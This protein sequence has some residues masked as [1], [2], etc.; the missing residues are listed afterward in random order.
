[1]ELF[2]L[3][4]QIALGGLVLSALT[5]AF[6]YLTKQTWRFKAVGYTGFLL[7]L[8]AGLLALS[9]APITRPKVEGAK[10]FEVVFD[11]GRGRIVIAVSPQIQPEE[12]ALTLK[13]ARIRRFSSAKGTFEV[14]ARTL[15]SVA[16]G[17]SQLIVL[18][19]LR[20]S[21]TAEDEI[22]IDPEGFIQLKAALAQNPTQKS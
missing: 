5:A 22:K 3:S 19:N 17:T 16:P 6:G 4:G 15:V 1:V 12:L 20:A 13:Q 11:R 18:G 21:A 14:I 7:V 9:L 8:T 2:L 10:S